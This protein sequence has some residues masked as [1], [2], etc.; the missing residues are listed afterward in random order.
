MSHGKPNLYKSKIHTHDQYAQ[1]PLCHS[2]TLITIHRLV[3]SGI[4]IAE[5]WGFL[6]REIKKERGRELMVEYGK[7]MRD[8]IIFSMKIRADKERKK[9]RKK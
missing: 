3:L 9:T 4:S 1:L 7:I 8:D 5:W 6:L 2:A